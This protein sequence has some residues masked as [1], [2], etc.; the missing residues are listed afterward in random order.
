MDSEKAVVNLFTPGLEMTPEIA[1]KLR[2]SGLYNLIIGIYSSEPA[3]HDKIRGISGAHEKALHAIRMAQEAGLMV[4][5]ACQV[6]SGDVDRIPEL[7]NFAA[8]V[9]VQ[10]LSIWEGIPL[11]AEEQLT[12]IEREKIIELYRSINSTPGGPRLF[13]STY[14]EGQMLGCM[15]GR[16]WLHVGVDGNVRAC[17]YLEKSYGNVFDIPIKDIWK[18]IRSSGEYDDFDCNCP[19]QRAFINY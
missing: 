17:P 15:A 19:A 3:L 6:K 9:G 18:T 4:T 10:E 14:F 5:M 8:S 11:T 7:Y 16:R 12:Q 13:A 1:V 2:E